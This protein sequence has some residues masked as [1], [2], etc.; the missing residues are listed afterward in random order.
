MKKVKWISFILLLISTGRDL[1]GEI[2]PFT[3]G[4]M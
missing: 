2:N 3:G 1:T 4:R